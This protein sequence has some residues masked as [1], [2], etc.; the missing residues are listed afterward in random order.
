MTHQAGENDS[1]LLCR[2]SSSCSGQ[3]SI[4]D[5]VSGV[6]ALLMLVELHLAKQSKAKYDNYPEHASIARDW[7]AAEVC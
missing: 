1:I 4:S 2:L 7:Q 3:R 6:P 5:R